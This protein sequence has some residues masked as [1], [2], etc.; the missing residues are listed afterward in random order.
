MSFI[1]DMIFMDKE[2]FLIS[3]AHIDIAW[4]W[5]W[6]EGFAEAL[7][8]FR[9]AVD[10]CESYDTYI[11]NHNEAALYEWIKEVDSELFERIQKLVKIG[12]WKIV[13]G[14]YIQPDCLLPKGESFIRQIM[15]GKRF[16]MDEFGVNIN[17]ATNYD[18][19][20]H[21]RGLVQILKNSGYEY[22]LVCRPLPDYMTLESDDFIWVGFD[23][24]EILVHRASEFY[25]SF[26]GQAKAKV[27]KYLLQKPTE[28]PQ[29]IMWGIGDHGG[30]PSDIDIKHLNK[31]IASSQISIKH[32][33]PVEYFYKLKDKIEHLPRERRALTPFAVGC[34]SS[35]ITL[36]QKHRELENAY[37]RAEKI[38]SH[39]ALLGLIP[40][41]KQEF[42]EIEKS[43]LLS[44]FHDMLPGSGTKRVENDTVQMLDS[45]LYT[46]RK[47]VLSAMIKLAEHTG[48]KFKDGHV[49]LVYYNPHPFAVTNI[50]EC[51]FNLPDHN[52]GKEVIIPILSLHGDVIESQLEAEESNLPSDWRK[53]VVFRATFPPMT[54]SIIDCEVTHLEEI[55]KEKIQESKCF[56]YFETK[57]LKIQINKL[58]GL[59]C[60]VEQN[61]IIYINQDSF[62]PTV[63]VDDSDSWGMIHNKFQTIDGTFIP[64]TKEELD[65]ICD[66]RNPG[67]G[68]LAIIENGPVRTVFESHF[69]YGNSSVIMYYYLPKKGTEWKISIR[70]FWNEH[71]KML[72]LVVPFSGTD[73]LCHADVPFGIETYH[74]DGNEQPYRNW[75]M[76]SNKEGH[77]VSI[78]NDGVNS[79]SCTMDGLQ[80]TLL[81]SPIYANH[82]IDYTDIK[83]PDSHYYLRM[84]QGE[85]FFNFWIN[86]GNKKDRIKNIN[87]EAD[88]HNEYILNLPYFP[89]G[90]KISE[91]KSLFI[92]DNEQ[93]QLVALKESEN[94][95]GFILRLRESIGSHT[96]TNIL[97]P[98]LSFSH[99]LE[100]K[101]FEIKTLLF[102]KQG[103]IHYT[104]LIE[105]KL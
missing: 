4:V 15:R 29:M 90:N 42:N 70:V 44:E 97:S 103:I 76:I 10:F 48:K 85:R 55:E 56:Y 17:L 46:C 18:S 100:F 92:I 52:H 27:E 77:S 12:K 24:S 19:F 28:N 66:Y 26:R 47:L 93:I 37:Y 87:R 9:V 98:E 62:I 11:F 105:R 95:N 13:G 67:M 38:R 86:Q 1:K 49:P 63:Y 78:I 101:P 68:A 82:P 79:L 20:G 43:L 50:F 102:Q 54:I 83:V 73:L 64:M 35:Q 88:C 39:S 61:G 94:S 65:N 69:I 25:Q 41:P 51:E 80:L 74:P 81:R 30:G 104:D 16:F 57:E 60:K 8:T 6:E 53:K 33:T 31:L 72:K 7:S 34:Y 23:E 3:N 45:G 36:K 91:I 58:T 14:W 75:T 2:V 96:V 40:Y 21:A 32:A 99:K 89:S 84:E 22:Y 59:I 5:N 71:E